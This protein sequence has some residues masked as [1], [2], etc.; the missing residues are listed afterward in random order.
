MFEGAFSGCTGLTTVDIHDGCEVIGTQCFYGCT[1][2]NSI[3]IPESVTSIGVEAFYGCNSLATATIGDGVTTIGASAFSGCE[4]L[5]SLTLGVGLTTIGYRAFYGCKALKSVELP[6]YLTDFPAKAYSDNS[7]A[8]AQCTSLTK[9]ILGK[10]IANM[11]DGVFSGCTNIAQIEIKDGCKV[12]GGK[13]FNGCDNIQTIVNNCVELPET[14]A[15]AFSSYTAALYVPEESFA[16][17]QTTEPWSKFSTIG[18]IE[19]GVPEPSTTKCATPTIK[20]ANGELTFECA[21]DDVEF[22]YEIKDNDV[23]TGSGSHVALACSYQISVYA[24][25][26]GY[27]NSD[28]ATYQL[29]LANK[30]PGDMD[31]NGILNAAD[32]VLLVDEVMKEEKK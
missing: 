8:F 19:G 6:D 5:S 1:S 9:V 24:K 11:G 28:T 13:C 18:T 20:Y 17:Y 25:K 14:A 4:T 7:E 3:D 21:T 2:L 15:N 32:V 30:L 29:E 22:V 10:R 31:G 27:E 23:S 26:A 16:T 12:I